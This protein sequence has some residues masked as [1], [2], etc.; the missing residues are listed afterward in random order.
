[1]TRGIE[2]RDAMATGVTPRAKGLTFVICGLALLLVAA[3]GGGAGSPVATLTSSAAPGTT[4][5][6]SESSGPSLA[7]SAPVVTAQPG[8]SAIG[9]CVAPPSGI[10]GWWRA[11]DDARDAIGP[12]DG[13]LQGGATFTDGM[14]GRAFTFDG[15]TQYVAVS[16]SAALQLK[17]AITLEG[18]VFAKGDLSDYAGIAG[19]WDDNT[20]ANRTYLFWLLGQT[21]E[22]I[23][24]PDHNAYQR[25]SDVTPFSTDRWVYVAATYDGTTLRLY[26][27]GME[28][29]S[30]QTAGQIAVNDKAFLIGRTEG[31][32]AGPNFWQGSIDEL[33]V[34]D[35][36]LT[37]AELAAIHAAG[38]AGKCRT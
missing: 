33:S 2:E 38:S 29:A 15:S 30:A 34:Y 27:D 13:T 36:A 37:A 23:V 9:A 14:V 32:S 26:R 28:V 35:R 4:T 5:S 20:G 21:M 18:W 17:T 7:P 16:P 19:T 1:L 6:G 8:A 11:E 31:G 12:H 10:V 24:S 25:V 22:F 3:C